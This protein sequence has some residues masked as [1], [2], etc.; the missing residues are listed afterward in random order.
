MTFDRDIL[1]EIKRAK[2][3]VIFTG[4]DIS[5]EAGLATFYNPGYEWEDYDISILSSKQGFE[6][7]PDLVW[8]WYQHRRRSV[9]KHGATRT[10][11]L[12]QELIDYLGG[13]SVI[14]Q[15]V[16]CLHQVSGT[17]NLIELHG[18]IFH[19]KCGTCSNPYSQYTIMSDEPQRCNKCGN[20][21]RP[22]VVWFGEEV[23]EKL[24]QKSMELIYNADVLITTGLYNEMFPASAF[25]ETAFDSNTFIFEISAEQSVNA[26]YVNKFAHGKYSTI[27]EN[28]L[29]DLKRLFIE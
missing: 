8:K 20:P 5:K 24:Y 16:D 27:L 12:I 17:K 1:F 26:R 7:K 6:S 21:V 2:N 13:G 15:N 9:A 23:D 10:H 28:L 11:S 14:T 3:L 18:N 22:C 4:A 25:I 19:S 29:K